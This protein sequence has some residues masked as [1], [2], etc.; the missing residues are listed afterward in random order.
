MIYEAKA[1][2]SNVLH[3]LV[4]IQCIGIKPIPAPRVL[5]ARSGSPP[6]MY[7]TCIINHPCIASIWLLAHIIHNFTSE[8]EN[9]LPDKVKSY[10]VNVT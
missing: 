6:I 8:S 10:S 7:S 3:F 4:Y 1:C 5:G 2:L 9:P